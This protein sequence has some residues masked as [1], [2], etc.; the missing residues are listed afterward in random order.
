MGE[1]VGQHPWKTL[2]GFTALILL[3]LCTAMYLAG[4]DLHA[5]LAVAGIDVALIWAPTLF[6]RWSH[7][8]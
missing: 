5:T 7:A 2:T 8:R 3:A 6:A 4:G 1:W